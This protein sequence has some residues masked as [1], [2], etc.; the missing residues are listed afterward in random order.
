MRLQSLLASFVIV[1]KP[2]PVNT[3]ST[4]FILIN[5]IASL[6]L[7]LGNMLFIK[8]NI[9]I[10]GATPLYSYLINGFLGGIFIVIIIIMFWGPEIAKMVFSTP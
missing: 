8:L 1:K 10:N 9:Y 2:G 4:P 3:D 6:L 7:F 5:C